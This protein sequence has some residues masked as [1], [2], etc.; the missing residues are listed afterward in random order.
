MPGHERQVIFANDENHSLLR[1]IYGP[2]FTPKAV[3]EQGDMLLKYADRLVATLK[4][5]ITERPVQ[6]MSAFYNF[7][8]FDLMGEFAFDEPFHCLDQGGKTH[9][10]MNTVL[11]GTI[12][13]MK[14]AQ[15]DYYGIW[16][17]LKPLIPK[18]F[19][20]PKLDMDNYTAAL[21]DRRRE[22]GYV[23]GKTDVYNYVLQ[24]KNENRL[25]RDEL[26]D[27]G[28]VLAVA[29]SETTA[30]LC[31]FFVS[32]NSRIEGALIAFNTTSD[33]HHMVPVPES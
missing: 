23:P 13:G 33:R 3:E 4:I 10:F 22:R 1:K 7:V 8:S 20:K 17:M 30:T 25:S 29:G 32:Y 27:N 21:I 6:D 14:L 11:E 16:S 28:V 2:A 19:Y 9:F 31:K 15:M 18:S 26:V 24:D 12:V 5:A